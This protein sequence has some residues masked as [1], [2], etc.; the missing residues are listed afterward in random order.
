MRRPCHYLLSFLLL[1][2]LAGAFPIKGQDNAS[3]NWYFG[4]SDRGIR[5]NRG[6]HTVT[7]AD[8]PAAT[9]NSA[10]GAVASNPIN[11][12]LLFF[13]DGSVIYD[14][15]GAPMPNGSGLSGNPDGNQPAVVASVPGQTNQY[16]VFTNTADYNTGGDIFL[17][18]VDMSLPGNGGNPSPPPPLGDVTSANVLIPALSNRSEAMLLIPHAN[19]TDYW[20]ITHENGT[21]NYTVSHIDASG[22]VT[23]TNYQNEGFA[24]SAGN[25]AYNAANGQIAVSPQS[26]N[27]GVHLMNFDNTTGDFEFDS[28]VP[29]SAVTATSGQAIYDVAWSSNGQYLYISVAGEP[30]IQADVLQYDTQNPSAT[31]ISVLPQPNSIANSY[32][33][34]MGPDSVIYHLYQETAGGPYLLGAISDTDTVATAVS[35]NPSVFPDDF[36]GTQ[37]PSFLPRSNQDITVDFTTSGECANSPVSFFPEVNPAADS[38]VWN[39]GDQT[40]SNQWSPNHSYQDGGVYTVTLTAYLNGQS[41]SV[42]H[43]VNITQFDLQ[44]DLVQD[45]TA[46]SCELPFP[47]APDPK[48]GCTQF[49][50]TATVQGGSGNALWSNGQTG[51]TLQPDSAGYYYVVVTDPNTGCSAYAGVNINEYQVQDQRANIWHFGQNAGIDF[52]PLPDNPA[53]AINGP[54][55]S[56]EGAASISDRNGQVIFST[57]GLNIYDKDGNPIPTPPT[58]PGLGGEPGAT[59]SVLIMPVPGD[60]T[61]YY[62]FTTQEIYG[63]GT[64]ELRYSL[65]DLKLNNGDGGLIEY[66]VLLFKPSTERITGSGEWLIAHEYGNNS[67]RAYRISPDGISSPVISGAGSDHPE[68]SPEA[69]QGYMK[70]GPGNKLAVALST[71]GSNVVE[72]FDFNDSTGVVSN[73]QVAD[74]EEP[75]GQ[76]YG[77]EFS[78]GGNKLFAT[79]TGND[80]K[81]FE[82]AFDSLG[83]VYFKQAVDKDGEELG[84]IQIGP[85]GQ[86]YMAINGQPFLYNIVP[87]EDTAALSPLN[88]LQQFPLEG[89]TSSTLGLP[90]FI[91]NISTP[92][93]GPSISVAGTCLGSP[94]DFNG[95]G[96]D[97]N[98]ETY[99]W[100]FGDGQGTPF[101]TDPTAQHQYAAAGTYNVSLTLRNRCDIDTV[102]HTTVVITAPPDSAVSVVGGLFPNLCDGPLELIA[103]ADGPDLSY[104]WSTGETTR[105]IEVNRQGLYTV[106]ITDAAGCTSTGQMPVAE[107]RPIVD[108][109][110]DLTLCQDSPT[111]DLDAQNP[112]FTYQWAIDG[113]NVGTSRTQSV[114]TSVPGTFE[115]SVAVTDQVTGCTI[116]DA[117]TFTINATPTFTATPIDPT[118]CGAGDGSIDINITTPAASL[119]TYSVTGGTSTPVNVSDQPV[120]AYS[121]PNL[122]AATY[123]VTVTDQLT[124]C[125][126][127]QTASINDSDFTVDVTAMGTCDPISLQVETDPDQASGNYRVINEATGQAVV[128]GPFTAASGVFT[129]PSIPGPS[130]NRSYI[131]E[132]RS[133]GCVVSST[134]LLI[135]LNDAVP[136]SDILVDACADPMTIEVVTEPGTTITWSGPGVPGGT[137]G[138]TLSVS[139]APQGQ[140]EFSFH[141]EHPSYCELDSVV[142]VTVDNMMIPTLA[143]S[144]ACD[145]QV[146]ITA[147][148]SGSYLYRWYRNGTLD[149]T[150]AGP[151]AIA[152]ELNDGESYTV[153]LYNPVTGCAPT[154]DPLVVSVI[155]ALELDLD[156]GLAC[157][158]SPFTITS[159]TNVPVT[160]YEWWYE[161]AVI[162]GQTASTL[163]DTRAGTYMARVSVTG[164]VTEETIVVALSPVT[165]GSL[166]SGATICNDPANADEETRQ[167]ELNPGEG[168]ASYTWFKDGIPLGVTDPVF[169]ATEPGTYRVDLINMLGCTSSDQTVVDVECMPKIVVPNAFRPGPGARNPEFYALTYFI[170]DTEFEVLIFSRWGELIFQSTNREFR[171]NGGYNNN[172]SKPL[173]PGTYAYVIKYKSSYQPERGVQEKRGGVVLLR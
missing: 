19:G 59:Q 54:V 89:G 102:L 13:T 123:T 12:N 77:I 166:P 143:Q 52:N 126:E 153:Q 21:A 11:G 48:T 93:Q 134:P 16:F 112:G 8:N 101:S 39:F 44:I 92:I 91:Q 45:T 76:V 23:S 114:D 133:S 136:V 87:N 163:E 81:I 36:G 70:L 127:V 158:G 57:D 99:S 157:E 130:D 47:K 88:M 115:Y 169:T 124:S 167:V 110:P 111:P 75:N 159:S 161:G 131:V 98:I 71:P 10:G 162:S 147:T 64:Y 14:A 32:G 106:T 107:N 83:N 78:P 67:F 145:D 170:D 94:T 144:S 20:L 56:P 65:F 151:Q 37:F 74:L 40:G 42:Q 79:V 84:A 25:F 116:T 154:S 103:E 49:S 35:Y 41:Q 146:T 142:T 86:L 38:L 30:G 150:L 50:V 61:L 171:W 118:S 85:D 108:L 22:V 160:T 63:T 66:N 82:F 5:F 3:L 4:S 43:D 165:P 2:L 119:F 80:S 90:N 113:S 46:C 128:T 132:V 53:V 58:P 24:M 97:P 28:V 96:R 68:T 139:N 33:L 55:N 17:T 152:T 1:L 164:C 109:G 9:F 15:S 104:V 140:Q 156:V 155:G 31:L 172:L 95:A 29:N 105:Q 149:N 51:L 27:V 122:N 168:F 141:A 72:I 73:P 173:P 117:V 100:N 34:Q 60:E 137:T 120:G 138:L 135:D 121:V 7:E 18:T 62:I 129:I 69:G 125:A 6:T 148:P 26:A